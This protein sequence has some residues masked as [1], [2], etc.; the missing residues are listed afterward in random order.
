MPG[1]D[2]GEALERQFA[3]APLEIPYGI[4]TPAPFVASLTP[5]WCLEAFYRVNP[6]ASERRYRELG[7]PSLYLLDF[8]REVLRVSPID[9]SG[10][11]GEINDLRHALHLEPFGTSGLEELVEAQREI[12][13]RTDRMIELLPFLVRRPRV[14]YRPSTW[15]GPRWIERR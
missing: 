6:G 3:E 9:R 12:N 1:E 15:F 13:R 14:W 10:A 2:R 11:L 4:A 5:E 7:W 8:A